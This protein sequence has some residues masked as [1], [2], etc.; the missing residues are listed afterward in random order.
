MFVVR[1]PSPFPFEAWGFDNGAFVAFCKGL[2]FP[3]SDFMRRLEQAQSV[4]SDPYMAVCPDIVA[5]GCTSLQFSASWMLS[6]KLPDWPW[7]LAVQDGMAVSDVEPYLHLYQGV[8]LGGTDKFKL[9]ALRW[10]DLAHAHQLP[11][12]YARAGTLR[13]MEHAFKVGADSLDSSF[14]LWSV[15][16]MKRFIWAVEG[17]GSQMEFQL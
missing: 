3:E 15:E 1:R 5:G 7:Y 9:Q 4:N 6:R 2:P 16:R 10:C 13:K 14:P 17:I 12:H 8:F 11:F